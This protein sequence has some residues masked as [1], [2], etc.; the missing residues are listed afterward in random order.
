MEEHLRVGELCKQGNGKERMQSL[1]L[2]G[3]KVA[4]NNLKE[5]KGQALSRNGAGKKGHQVLTIQS[6]RKK[7]KGG[8]GMRAF[9]PFPRRTAGKGKNG[10]Q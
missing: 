10:M 6:S 5:K 9:H 7:K 3:K 2:E 1:L 8:R 4:D